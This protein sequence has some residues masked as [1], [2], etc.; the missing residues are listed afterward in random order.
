MA[1]AA[2]DLGLDT[3]NLMGTSFGGKVA[4]WL[5]VQQPERVQAL[6]L[7]APAAIRPA[8]SRA[9]LRLAGGDGAPPLRP[10]RAAAAVLPARTRRSR[11]DARLWSAAARSRPRRRSRSA[12]CAVSRCRPWCCSA[13]ATAVIPPEMGRIYKELLPNCHLVFVYD[14]GHAISAERPEAFAEVGRFPRTPRSLCDQP[15]RDG[16]PPLAAGAGSAKAAGGPAWRLTFAHPRY[17]ARKPLTRRGS[18]SRDG[19]G[20]RRRRCYGGIRG[21]AAR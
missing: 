17:A 19:G 7:E 18:P 16:D 2:E 12:A 4:L 11:Q 3:F 1:A 6:V 5:A 14:A 21:P 13:R 20:A 15:H 10:S 9:A 8:G